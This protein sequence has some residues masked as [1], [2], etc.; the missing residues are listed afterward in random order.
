MSGGS[1]QA[2]GAGGEVGAGRG[3]APTLR[4]GRAA[5]RARWASRRRGFD[6]P[7]FLLVL[8]A[9]VF[10]YLFVP[11][12]VVV[13]FSFN[14]EQS[15]AIFSGFSLRWYGQ[16]FGDPD[17][18]ASVLASVEIGLATT[19]LSAVVGTLLA[20]GLQR[21]MPRL[22]GPTDTVL[23]LRL[24]S[25]EITAAI[26]LFLLFTQLGLTLS[27]GTI[28][29]AHVSFAVVYVA[30]IVRSRL[31]NL[32]PEIEEA[33]MDLGATEL[34]SLRLVSLPLLWPAI[35][36][37]SILVFVMS[38]DDFITSYFTTGTGV[39]PLP[40]RIYAMIKFGVSPV[41][42]AIGT[43]MMVITVLLAMLALALF[44]LHGAVRSR[45]QA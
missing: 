44:A 8:T 33:A 5:S 29:L 12:V 15:L 2:Y 42:N 24:A 17:I 38:F 11:I 18:Q 14:S 3:Q 30:V 19:A 31:A 27:L 4:A 9:L 16:F 32:N 37:S 34:Q 25:P 26:G 6:R 21:A 41:I 28:V 39:P 13:L 1:R 10:V 43:F 35:L 40:V 36:A 22:T 45:R 20:F 23:L 7:R